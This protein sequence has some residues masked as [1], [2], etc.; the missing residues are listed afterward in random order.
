[1]GFIITLFCIALVIQGFNL[2]Y[3]LKQDDIDK[4]DYYYFD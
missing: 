3:L 1:M 2:A 4:D